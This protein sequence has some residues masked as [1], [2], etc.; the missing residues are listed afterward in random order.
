M[1]EIIWFRSFERD[2]LAEITW[3]R[4]F[5]RGHWAEITWWRSF[6]RDLL[7]EITWLRSFGRDHRAEIVWLRPSEVGERQ[8][9]EFYTKELIP[10]RHLQKDPQR[11]S[12]SS[13]V[14][15]SSPH[16]F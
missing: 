3:L 15:N 13:G 12:A 11:I 4:S 6:G 10:H 5:G 16:F 9:N 7:P 1:V 14:L 8:L 2:H